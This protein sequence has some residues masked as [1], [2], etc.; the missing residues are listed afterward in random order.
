MFLPF[1]M[2]LMFPPFVWMIESCLQDQCVLFLV[3]SYS[4]LTESR[5]FLSRDDNVWAGF[6]S[7]TGN[8]VE[9]LA[10]ETPFQQV[11]TQFCCSLPG[12]G[13]LFTSLGGLKSYKPQSLRCSSQTT[14]EMF[15]NL[16]TV[17]E[18]AEILTIPRAGS[19]YRG[20]MLRSALTSLPEF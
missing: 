8:H 9:V 1:S 17:W 3:H 14:R 10:G 2:S 15:V 16:S 20:R 6:G 11:S 5:S 18:R 19:L 7:G 4:A 12:S 13:L